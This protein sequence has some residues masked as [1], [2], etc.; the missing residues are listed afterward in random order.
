ML[1]LTALTMGVTVG[2]YLSFPRLS[3]GADT[4]LITAVVETEPSSSFDAMKQ[5][6]QTVGDRLRQDPAVQS[7]IA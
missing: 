3:A 5:M 6:Q 1:C 2:L 4:G 7:V